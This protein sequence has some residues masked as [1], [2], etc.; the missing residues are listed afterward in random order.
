MEELN[1]NGQVVEER[2]LKD[3]VTYI[4]ADSGLVEKVYKCVVLLFKSDIKEN[5]D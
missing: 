3:L 1:D 2:D 4:I 5:N